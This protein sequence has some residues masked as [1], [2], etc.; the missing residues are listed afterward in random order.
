MN[1]PIIFDIETDGL[2]PSKVHCLVLQKDGEEIS[3]VGRDIPKGIDLLADNL[4]VGHNVIKYDLPVLK[5]LYDYNHSPDLVHD[6]LC[7]SR[8]IYPDIA[9]SV[10]Y[11][12]L[13]SDRIERTSVGKHSLKAWGQRLNFHKGDFAEIN[14]FDM[15][16]PAMLEYCIQDVKLT[17]LLYKKLLEKGFSKGSIEL[18]HEVAEKTDNL[19]PKH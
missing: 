17:S 2:N 4:I 18:E 13:A 7:L 15:F 11:K 19:N 16:T 5:R 10:D 8:L 1:K 9:N 3:F 14:T 6:T 12:L